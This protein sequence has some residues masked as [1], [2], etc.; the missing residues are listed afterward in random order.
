[1]SSSV[2][3]G[4]KFAYVASGGFSLSRGF[5]A[6]AIQPVVGV[7][8]YDMTN[9]VQ[10]EFDVR[11]FNMKLGI[12]KEADHYNLMSEADKVATGSEYVSR[13]YDTTLDAFYDMNTGSAVEFNE[14][15]LD[16]S[17][18]IAGITAT[19][20]IVSVGAYSSVYSDYEAAVRQYFGYSGG[21]ATLFA[22]AET[23]DIAEAF[24]ATAFYALLQGT[25][26]VDATNGY[27]SVPTGTIT[28][29]NVVEILRSAVDSNMFENRDISGSDAFASDPANRHNYGVADGFVA[30]DVIWI[31]A[32]TTINLSVGID[33]EVVSLYLNNIGPENLVTGSTSTVQSGA[34]FSEVT[35]SN[36]TAITRVISVPMV[37]RL[38][39]M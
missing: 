30:G 5:D 28:I 25:D 12:F 26:V 23:F 32:G 22:N 29:S 31:P 8:Q 2:F 6:I 9:T 10:I 15:T 39:N 3:V 20:Q 14:I 1:M 4:E 16:A 18:L 34:T 33:S 36:L 38:V 13:Y 24:D 19:S 35:T 11:T 21:F 37:I 7:N 27:V 17:E